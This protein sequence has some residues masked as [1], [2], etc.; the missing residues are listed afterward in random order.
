LMVSRLSRMPGFSV[1]QPEG[2]FY[3]FPSIKQTGKTSLQIAE[4]L[5]EEASV[6]LVPGSAFGQSGEGYL[7]IS[8]ANSYE[9]LEEGLDNMERA[10][11][12]L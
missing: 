6:A 4:Y 2:A 5:L 1:V 11:A 8:Y 10:L 7:R 3:V 12:R 9:Q